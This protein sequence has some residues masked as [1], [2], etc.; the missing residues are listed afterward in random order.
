MATAGKEVE[1][2]DDRGFERRLRR[3]NRGGRFG[4]GA[5]PPSEEILEI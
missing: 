4:R 3:R 1:L 5:K 2:R